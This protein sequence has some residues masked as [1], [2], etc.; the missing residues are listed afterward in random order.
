[1]F[2]TRRLLEVCR[3]RRYHSRQGILMKIRSSLVRGICALLGMTLLVSCGSKE[4]SS[5]SAAGA[6]QDKRVTVAFVTNNPSDFWQIAK[7][8]IEK[9]QGEFNVSCDFQMP[10]DGTAADQ[11]RIVEA[12]LAK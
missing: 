9:A 5:S 1:M 2:Q 7:A 6:K 8:G 3:G 4:S 10:P 12:L 11:Q